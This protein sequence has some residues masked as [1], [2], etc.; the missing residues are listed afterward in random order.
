[1]AL[2]ALSRRND[3]PEPVRTAHEMIERNVQL[4]AHFIDDMLDVTRIARGKM[5][6]V[7]ADMD[8]HD[9]AR[10]AVEVSSPDLE[11][12]GQTLT[13]ALESTDH[14]LHGDFARLQ[15]AMWNLLKNASKFTPAGGRIGLRSWNEPGRIVVE[16][17]DTGIGM[18]A[19]V[20][21]RIFDPFEQA[22]P[23]IAKRFGGL[24]LGLAIAKA[25]VEAHDGELLADSAGPGL[26]A[27]F[28]MRLPLTVAR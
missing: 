11:G 9:A 25:A 7:R 12:K 3:L 14:R 26:G 13:V 1:M 5:E 10:R 27:T 8:L 15:Q 16:I 6:I 28:T 24:G 4:E 23:S 21:S 22:D 19:D 18:E 2:N 20:V 17:T